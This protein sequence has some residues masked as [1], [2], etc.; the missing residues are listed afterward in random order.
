MVTDFPVSH[1]RPKADDLSTKTNA[2][3][4][5]EKGIFVETVFN[6]FL[7][8]SDGLHCKLRIQQS[9]ISHLKVIGLKAQLTDKDSESLSTLRLEDL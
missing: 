8:V 7:V 9:E 3:D 5:A 1:A 4:E 6:D 2:T